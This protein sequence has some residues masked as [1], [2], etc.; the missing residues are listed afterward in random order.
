MFWSY[1][2]SCILFNVCVLSALRRTFKDVLVYLI[3]IPQLLKRAEGNERSWIISVSSTVEQTLSIILLNPNGPSKVEI[4]PNL[5][6]RKL[7]LGVWSTR[8]RFPL[9]WDTHSRS[10]SRWRRFLILRLNSGGRAVMGGPRM[11]SWNIGAQKLDLGV[12]QTGA[13]T[14]AL[15]SVVLWPQNTSLSVLQSKARKWTWRC[16]LLAQ[17]DRTITVSQ[18]GN[19]EYSDLGH[20]ARSGRWQIERSRLRSCHLSPLQM[21]GLG[22]IWSQNCHHL[23]YLADLGTITDCF[24]EPLGWFMSL[25]P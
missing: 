17:K 13:Q 14:P 20:L 21:P 11:R 24:L 9:P 7:R 19:R 3:I 1:S 6:V 8:L 22:I 16:Y 18:T 25:F 12:K 5:Q 23:D 10:L 2:P 15:W 4:S